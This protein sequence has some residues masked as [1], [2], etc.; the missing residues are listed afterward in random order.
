M[1]TVLQGPS[2]LVASTGLILAAADLIP[3]I[4]GFRFAGEGDVSFASL[5][6]LA[7]ISRDVDSSRGMPFA[8]FFLGGPFC[9]PFSGAVVVILLRGPFPLSSHLFI[10][11]RGVG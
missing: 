8:F 5:Q 9:G 1:S 11:G 10:F 4:M 6:Y 3:S 2:P 7:I